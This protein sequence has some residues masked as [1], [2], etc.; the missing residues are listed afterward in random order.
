[1]EVV[2]NLCNDAQVLKSIWFGKITGS[3]HKERLESFYG[4]QAHVYDHFRARFLHGRT[5]MLRACAREMQ[6][7]QGRKDL[8]WVDL[9]GGTGQNVETMAGIC[10]L[11]LFKKVYMVDI[12]GPLCE[13]ARARVAKHGWTNVEVVE[14]D[15]C[16][17]KPDETYTTL[18]TF[19]YSLSMIPPFLNALD[20]ASSYLD[21]A[22]GVLGVADF[23]TSLKHDKSERQHGY[24]TRWFWRS[25]FDLDNIDLGPER[26][27][28]MDYKFETVYEENH[29]GHI[30]YVP[31]LKVPYYIWLGTRLGLLAWL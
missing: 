23:F 20:K 30:P 27:Q 28:Y 15:V 13:I 22:V 17:Y 18:V 6:K 8:V 4:P 25:I 9:G 29:T 19:S 14:A 24:L 31:F 11:S 7:L 5:G 16:D 10:D 3:T 21:P 26:R 12:C 2:K 1:M